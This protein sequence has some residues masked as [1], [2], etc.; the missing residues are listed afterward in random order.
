MGYNIGMNKT[1]FKAAVY[2]RL[3]REDED[4]FESESIKNQRDLLRKYVLNQG[5]KLVDIYIDD[6]YTGTNFNRPDFQR[7]IKDI[8]KGKINLVITKDLSR[9]GRDYISTGYYLEKYFP[10]KDIRYIALNDAIDTFASSAGNDISPFKSVINDMYARDISNKV[11]SVMDTKKREGKFIGAFAPFG[12]KKDLNDKNKLVIDQEVA[13]IIKRIF[14]MYLKDHGISNIAHTLNSERI[15]TPTEYKARK[16]NYKGTAST[17]LW[18]HATVR[19]ILQNPTYKGCMTQNKQK[20]VSYKSKKHKLLPEGCWVVV[21]HTHEPIIDP[22]TFD[23]VQK[24]RK[25][26]NNENYNGKKE[27]KLFSGFVFC[28]DCGSYMTYNKTSAAYYLIC[29]RYKRHTSEYCTR[30]AIKEDDLKEIILDDIKTFVDYSVDKQKLLKEA[31]NS[32]G[33]SPKNQVLQEIKMLEIKLTEIKKAVRNLY[34]DKVK[35]IIDE[36]EF[37]EI[38]KEFAKEKDVLN[39][40][41]E[42]LQK[43]HEAYTDRKSE[44]ERMAASVEEVINIK[45]LNRYI[46]EQLIAQIEIYEDQQVKIHYTFKNP[47][48]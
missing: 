6:G 2:C 15:M 39:K 28:G 14:H 16:T 10:E 13:P 37:I 38:K 35:G 23:D 43:K 21:D 5:W 27:L 42:W 34:T 36:E 33:K 4:S 7:L 31:K 3:S 46:L 44:V 29:S 12:Y 18:T 40:R 32:T 17:N 45:E 19:S 47:T 41:Y 24:L 11:R 26:K 20:K 22:K 8:E 1:D 30:H 48:I 25:R 9:L